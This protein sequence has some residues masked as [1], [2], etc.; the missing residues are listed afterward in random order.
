MMLRQFLNPP[1]WFTSAS[2]F[3]GLYAIL[4]SG[5][6]N[7]DAHHF[8]KAGLM[9][10]FAGLFDGLDGRVVH[11]DD[12]TCMQKWKFTDAIETFWSDKQ[13]GNT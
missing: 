8:Y 2:L 6:A 11:L 9:I 7:G 12:F 13:N 5:T 4:L 3:C 10:F 1:N